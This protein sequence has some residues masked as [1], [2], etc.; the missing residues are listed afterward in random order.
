VSY[1]DDDAAHAARASDLIDEIARLE[2]ERVTQ[3]SRDQR[4]EAAK[5]EL[6]TLQPAA[7]RSSRGPGV[8]AHVV[9][10][11]ATA[12]TAYAGYALWF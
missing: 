6:A 10:F 8:V 11:V 1:R 12:S 5:R 3:V 2:H 4:L 7:D 9:V